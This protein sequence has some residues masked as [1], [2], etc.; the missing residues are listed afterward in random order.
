MGEH[1]PTGVLDFW[2]PPNIESGMCQHAKMQDHV[3]KASE[4]L[5]ES[6]GFG[7]RPPQ[8]KEI[9]VIKPAKVVIHLQ[10]QS[11]QVL[12]TLVH[13]NHLTSPPAASPVRVAPVTASA[14]VQAL[15]HLWGGIVRSRHLFGHLLLSAAGSDVGKRYESME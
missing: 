4:Y 1:R 3:S 2:F 10:S 7:E 15:M 5:G 14:K 6:R 9:A 13:F 11:Q 12:D 8:K